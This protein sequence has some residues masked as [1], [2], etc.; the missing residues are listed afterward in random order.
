MKSKLASN[1]KCL[2][3]CTSTIKNIPVDARHAAAQVG[4]LSEETELDRNKLMQNQAFTKAYKTCTP[5]D[6][7]HAAAQVGGLSEET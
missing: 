1:S 5:V 4:G 6:V 2:R 7:C 3:S